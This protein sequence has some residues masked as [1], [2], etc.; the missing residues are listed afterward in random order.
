MSA[1]TTTPDTPVPAPGPR[2]PAPE[3]APIPAV[4]GE[5]ELRVTYPADSAFVG[6][7]D[8]NFIFGSTGNGEARLWIDGREVDVRPNGAFLAFLPVP[9]DSVYRL[10]ATLGDRSATLE[11]PISLPAPVPDPGDSALIVPGSV[12]PAGAWVALP[13][14]R[15]PASFTGSA[16][17]R[18]WVA[19]ADGTTAPLVETRAGAGGATD[20][21]VGADSDATGDVAGD[22]ADRPL[23]TYR[24]FFTARRVLSADTTTAWPALTG[25][26]RP[27][28]PRDTVFERREEAAGAPVGE[29]R[30]EALP[31]EDATDPAPRALEGVPGAGAAVVLAVRGDTVVRPL[32]LNL[33]LADPDRPRVGVG[34]DPDPPERNGDDH[35]IARPGPGGGPYHY[36]WRNGVELELT[37][38]RNGA[39]RVRLTD[40]LSAW[41]PAADVRLRPAGA[42]LPVSRVATV[43]LDPQPGWVDVRVNVG[44]RLPYAVTESERSFSL[45]V[46]GATSRASF[47]QHGRVDPYIDRAEWSQPADRRFR[48]DIHLTRPAWGYETF[49]RGDDLV[50]R[51]NRPPAIDPAAPLR[52][53]TIGIDP[54][55]G[56]AHDGAVGP[57]GLREAEANLA[58]ALPL[59][60][61]LEA[62]GATVVMTRTDDATVSLVE[63]TTLARERDVDLLVSVHNNAF[64]D[65]IDPWQNNGTSVYYTHARAAGLAWSV[66][67]ALL[68][69]LG[70]RDI[71]VG[72]ADLH[73]PRFTWAPSILTE[74]AFMMVPVQEAFLNGEEGP[75][76]IAEAHVRGIVDWLRAVGVDE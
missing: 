53:L 14:E 1:C 47:L 34:R 43:R 21:D 57:T 16:G 5:L 45:H 9:A 32:P 56:G 11:V 71:G 40:D 35:V 23:A 20:F 42:P 27:S 12:A 59:R 75:R 66:H 61:R 13:G 76:R 7:R 17:G 55:H 64:P 70:L 54:G 63:R 46:F 30:R 24:G 8:R 31:V 36:V 2:P 15:V 29:P 48:L 25:E 65:G 4:R 74:T 37:G 26:A 22:T 50:L 18:A 60:D 72:R 62:E 68:G 28:L 69:E 58:I 52:G 38:E 39:Y 19:F 44:G 6:T 3:L 67:R 10:R 33:L 73:L 49:W 51:L 41:T